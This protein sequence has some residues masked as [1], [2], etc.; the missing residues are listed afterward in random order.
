MTALTFLQ[1]NNSKDNLTILANASVTPKGTFCATKKVWNMT[2]YFSPS[3]SRIREIAIGLST[4]VVLASLWVM[5]LPKFISCMGSNDWET[6]FASA[7]FKCLSETLDF[8]GGGRMRTI[9]ALFASATA[10]FGIAAYAG[11]S[12]VLRDKSLQKRY[13]ALDAVYTGVAQELFAQWEQAKTPEDK[14][15]VEKIAKNLFANKELIQLSLQQTV[16]LQE[17]QAKCL[18]EKISA[19]TQ[20]V[21]S[22]ASQQFVKLPETPQQ[23]QPSLSAKFTAAAKSL[24]SSPKKDQPR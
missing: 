14:V 16:R 10:L 18:C 4:S 24:F 19:A 13:D 20:S 6:N 15:A 21:L 8:G 1:E 12:Y 17:T 9:Q 11:A 5:V 2:P 3:Q 23:Q 22:S 7:G